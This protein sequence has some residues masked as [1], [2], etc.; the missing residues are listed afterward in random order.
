MA[1]D[2]VSNRGSPHFRSPFAVILDGVT[3]GAWRVVMTDV[4]HTKASTTTISNSRYS[5]EAQIDQ[6][7]RGAL[8]FVS[9]GRDRRRGS[10][11]SG[12]VTQSV[13]GPQP[14]V[15]FLQDP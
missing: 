9:P 4:T 5:S 3:Y 8:T 1:S 7:F 11:P 14:C 12:H 6:Q 15:R 13:D 2:G 10:Y